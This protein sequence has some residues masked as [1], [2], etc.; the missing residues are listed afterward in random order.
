MLQRN[1]ADSRTA[2]AV[3]VA[4]DER[5][6]TLDEFTQAVIPLT[7]EALQVLATVLHGCA[8]VNPAGLSH[9]WH[10]R[11]I[12]SRLADATRILN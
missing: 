8:V 1:D 11:N 9:L 2:C 12:C 7:S 5:E 4:M 6:I 10:A 3:L